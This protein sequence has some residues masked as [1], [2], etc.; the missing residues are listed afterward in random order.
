M[1]FEGQAPGWESIRLLKPEVRL[2]KLY[3]K[4]SNLL[5]PLKKESAD[6]E[7]NKFLIQSL[8]RDV[9]QNFGD[10]NIVKIAFALTSFR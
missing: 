3:D 6:V 9:Q 8:T 4:T 5:D 10:L 2:F 1:T 7:K